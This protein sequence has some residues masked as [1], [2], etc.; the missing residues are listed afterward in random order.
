METVRA[1]DGIIREADAR[2][3]VSSTS[4][5][6]VMIDCK[7]KKATPSKPW[8]GKVKSYLVINRNADAHTVQHQVPTIPITEIENENNRTIGLNFTC[9]V[10]CPE[11]SEDKVAEA[12]FDLELNP[13]DKFDRL[14]RRWVEDFADVDQT[15]FIRRYFELKAEL[16]KKIVDLARLKMGLELRVGLWLDDEA[17]SFRQ[18]KI[19][20]GSFLIRANDYHEQQDLKITCQLEI[21]PS[22]KIYANVYRQ[23]VAQLKDIL[24]REAQSF[25]QRN[26]TLEMFYDDLNQA[27]IVEP[28]KEALNEKLRREGRVLGFLHLE[29]SVVDSAPKNF[30]LELDVKVKVQEFPERIT[31]KNH[32][33][34]KRKNVA[35]Y[36]NEGSRKLDEWLTEKLDEIIPDVLFYEKYIDLLIDFRRQ[37]D[38][39]DATISGDDETGMTTGLKRKIKTKLS[40]EAQKIGYE[41]KYLTT[42][43][44]V[45]PLSW[46]DPFTI[47]VE[48]S[49]ET[50][51]SNFFVKVSIPVTVRLTTLEDLHVRNLLNSQ[52]DIPELMRQKAHEITSQFIHTVDPERF[53]TTFS[54]PDADK[55]EGAPSIEQDLISRITK[56]LADKFAADVISVV[57]KMVDTEPIVRWRELREKVCD[58]SVEVTPLRGGEAI[59]FTG[60][61]HVK[62]IASDGWDKF[63]NRKFTLDD[64]RNYLEA[65]L[66]AKLKT[67]SKN[68]LLIKGSAHLKDLHVVFDEIAIRGIREVYGVI[69]SIS[70]IDRDFTRLEAAMNMELNERGYSAILGA[71]TRR[72][73]ASSADLHAAEKKEEEIKRLTQDRLALGA[74]APEDEIEELEN[75][76]K[77]EREK[78]NPDLVP[79]IESIEQMLSPDLAGENRLLDV[80]KYRLLKEKENRT[81]A[82][83]NGQGYDNE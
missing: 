42:I 15:D 43:P 74:D 4:E 82:D 14:I 34:M 72:L 60:K 39:S 62:D 81:N 12:L 10:S 8:L 31:I 63:Q 23:R 6:F 76:I 51:I 65:D 75:R 25:F 57:P 68:E 20:T 7:T 28:L 32:A 53:Y 46:L 49:F 50:K 35:V 73:A 2:P 61:F 18:L 21:E 40:N 30:E 24:V 77:A 29:S 33:R 45:K 9:W 67:A 69:I 27:A 54:F 1:L 5:K 26:V 55:Y 11:G 48:G 47:V 79:S 64:I 52:E 70:M 44:N 13:S 3:K 71:Q 16:C 22:T 66:R 59:P 17:T 80:S 37:D 58:F 38:E 83:Q 56:A 36:K 78:L 19:E 41:L